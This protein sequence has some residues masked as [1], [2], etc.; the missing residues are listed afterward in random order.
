MR[1][2]RER[3]GGSQESERDTVRERQSGGRGSR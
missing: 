1:D 3:E 2:R